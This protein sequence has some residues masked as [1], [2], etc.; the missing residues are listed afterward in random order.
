MPYFTGPI[1]HLVAIYSPSP[2][3]LPLYRHSRH[4]IV[5]CRWPR[6]SPS[7]DISSFKFTQYHAYAHTP[8]LDKY[9]LSICQ[10]TAYAHNPGLDKIPPLN[11]PNHAYAHTPGLNKYLPSS[12]YPPPPTPY[13]LGRHLR[14]ILRPI[15]QLAIQPH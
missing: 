6:K 2:D 14:P 15:T 1:I 4:N 7:P 9:L 5:T 10:Y 3:L 12:S 11:L 8:K 13:I